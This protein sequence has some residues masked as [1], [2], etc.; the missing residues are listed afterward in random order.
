MNIC[1]AILSWKSGQTLI[2]TLSS[3]RDNGLLDVLDETVILF[4]EISDQD[5]EI[6]NHF[7]IRYIGLQNNIGI[8]KGFLTLAKYCKSKFIIPLEHDWLAVEP[9]Y[10]IE[11]RLKDSAKLLSAGLEVRVVRL[12]H[13]YNFGHPNF[14]LRYE[15]CN[16]DYY[17]KETRGRSSH[18][19]D[20][21]YSRE[22]PDKDFPQIYKT[23][24]TYQKALGITEPY[25]YTTANHSAFSNNPS[26]YN[27]EWYISMIKNHTGE[28]H[29]FEGKMLPIWNKYRFLVAQSTGLFKHEDCKKYGR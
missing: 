1:G 13:R 8:G 9:K 26:M 23:S 24:E 16:W 3:Y 5:I 29:Y 21:I 12:R 28:A 14:S 2:N 15:Q 7:G 17:D 19:L 6:A 25:Y 27:R 4:Q 18:L 10:I 20:S 22:N 11:Q